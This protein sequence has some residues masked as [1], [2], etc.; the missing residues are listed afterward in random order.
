[1]KSTRSQVIRKVKLYWPDRDLDE[2]MGILDQYGLKKYETGGD[3]V[4]MAVIK[5]SEGDFDRLPE[6]IKT[7]KID[8]RDVLAW[9][10]YPREFGISASDMKLLSK[11]EA[12]EIRRRDRKQYLDWLEKS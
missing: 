3:R 1:M 10:E 4:Q 9:A 6:L 2:V 11:G 12:E 5:L 8:Y 7:A